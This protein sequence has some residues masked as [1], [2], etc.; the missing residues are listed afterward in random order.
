MPPNVVE[1]EDKRAVRATRLPY[2]HMITAPHRSQRVSDFIPAAPSTS[3]M[4]W[5]LW[6]FSFV[7]KLAATRTRR[8]FLNTWFQVRQTTSAMPFTV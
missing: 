5:L 2:L 6:I 4:R 8:R 3:S 7:M 1:V